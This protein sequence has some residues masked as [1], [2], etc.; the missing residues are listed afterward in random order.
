MFYLL[1]VHAAVPL[2]PVAVWPVLCATN[3]SR[4]PV[5]EKRKHTIF[6]RPAHGPLGVVSVV[7]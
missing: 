4:L 3:A 5:F 2:V 6:C 7:L 1:I